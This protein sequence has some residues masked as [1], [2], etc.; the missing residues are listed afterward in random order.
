MVVMVVVVVIIPA[1][2][3]IIVMMMV[4]MMVIGGL[5]PPLRQRHSGLR[6]LASRLQLIRRFYQ[7]GRIWNRL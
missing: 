3:V 1:P 5:A 6:L 4:M 7:L 2:P